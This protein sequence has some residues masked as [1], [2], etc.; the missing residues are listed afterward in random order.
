MQ[1]LTRA[2][3]LRSLVRMSERRTTRGERAR[4][5][6]CV[7]GASPTWGAP[8]GGGPRWALASP[9]AT[10]ITSTKGCSSTSVKLTNDDDRHT[11]FSMKL[12]GLYTEGQ[13]VDWHIHILPVDPDAKEPVLMEPNDI[14]LNHTE[15]G[16][17]IVVPGNTLF[18][19][20]KPCDMDWEDATEE[21][22]EDPVVKF[23]L[24]FSC[25]THPGDLVRRIKPEW[26]KNGGVKLFLK[27]LQTHTP[28][29]GVVLW[30][31]YKEV[32]RRLCW[33]SALGC[34]RRRGTGWR[35]TQWML[36][37]TLD[38]QSHEH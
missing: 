13:K 16:A 14:S 12:C 11:E 15:M 1:K 25:D 3:N 28:R 21:D 27:Q 6:P 18:Q 8:R 34:W 37:S 30:R 36:T 9:I 10:T 23:L 4:H 19:R 22:M 20:R 31:M 35:T 32:Q 33:P 24:S 29:D 38:S 26:E 7:L 2:S 17:N 5:R